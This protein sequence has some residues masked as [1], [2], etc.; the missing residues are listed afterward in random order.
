M[1]PAVRAVAVTAVCAVAIGAVSAAVP[2]DAEGPHHQTR[3]ERV[4]SHPALLVEEVAVQAACTVVATL[5]PEVAVAA[6][7]VVKL[8][9]V[10]G[11]ALA[12]ASE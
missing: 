7:A 2:E 6:H 12:A 1:H 5:G 10:V 9:R 4:S 3:T 8:G 11:G